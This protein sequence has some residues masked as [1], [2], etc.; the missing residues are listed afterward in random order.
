VASGYCYMCDAPTETNPC[1]TCGKHLPSAAPAV[2]QRTPERRREQL[3][4]PDISEVKAPRRS[5]V[6]VV[7]VGIILLVIIVLVLR[8]DFGV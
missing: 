1:A 8:S 5:I 2:T 6:A 4:T 7:A 3:L